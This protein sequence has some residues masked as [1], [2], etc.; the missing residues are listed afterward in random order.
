M[1]LSSVIPK[2]PIV[3]MLDRI[4]VGS[5]RMGDC[6]LTAVSSF[7]SRSARSFTRAAIFESMEEILSRK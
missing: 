1:G 6:N 5:R 7:A 2:T 4:S 3:K